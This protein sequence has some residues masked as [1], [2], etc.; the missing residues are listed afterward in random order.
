MCQCPEWGD[1]QFYLESFP[2]MK[3]LLMS[4][5]ALKGATSISTKEPL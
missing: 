5:K 1:L 4:V 2:V 3:A